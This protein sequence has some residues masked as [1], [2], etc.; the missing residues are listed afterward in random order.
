MK[1]NERITEQ[2]T[3]DALRACH[4]YSREHFT[5]EEQMSGSLMI[6][7]LLHGASKSGSG[8]GK[9]E[10][11]ITSS[12]MKDLLIVIECKA[13]IRKH[14]SSSLDKVNDYAVDGALHYARFLSKGYNVIAIGISGQSE[15][16]MKIDT[17]FWLKKDTGFT[18]LPVKEILT[19]ESYITLIEQNEGISKRRKMVLTDEKRLELERKAYRRTFAWA[20]LLCPPVGIF[21][22][23]KIKPFEPLLNKISLWYGG[24]G[25]GIVLGVYLKNLIT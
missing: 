20:I 11:I 5:I 14:M 3:R 24:A 7:A 6:S 18:K 23:K 15:K 21:I 4:Y 8:I 16:E 9:P 10:F 22:A 19:L 25:T 2:L 1:I 12:F 13:D 17:Y